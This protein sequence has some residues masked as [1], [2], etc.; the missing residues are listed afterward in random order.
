MRGA[1]ISMMRRTIFCDRPARGGSTT[2]TSGL[3]GLL[4]QRARG[5]AHVAGEELRVVDAVQLRVLDRVGDRALDDLDAPD[6]ARVAG[7]RQRDRA[8][9]AVEVEDLLAAGQPASSIAIAVEALGHLGV[10][11]EERLGRD[12]EAQA[13]RAPPRSNSLPAELLRLALARGL[14]HALRRCPENAVRARRGLDERVAVEVALAGHE[15]RL[16]LPG[17]PPLAHDEVAQEA[18]VRRGGRRPAGPARAPSALTD[19][20]SASMRSLARMSSVTSSTRS[21]RPGTVEAQHELAVLVRCRTS[22]R[23]CCGS[24]TARLGGDDRLDRRILEAAD[25]RRAPRGPAA[26]SRPAGARRAAPARARPGARARGSI[27]SGLGSS[28]STARASA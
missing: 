19:S 13:G 20:R 4:D 26:P 22:T 14:G 5:R 9:A 11:L 18:R 23:A 7:Q 21:Q 17:A 6:L 24:A 25:A 2:M 12:A 10:G 16:E 1:S 15:P 3:P 28:I 8:A 27:R